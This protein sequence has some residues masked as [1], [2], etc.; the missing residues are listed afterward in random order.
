MNDLDVVQFVQRSVKERKTMVL[1]LL[2]N[3]GIKNMEHYQLCMGELNA[4][5]FIS[6]ELSSL[7]EQQEQFD[8]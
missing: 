7:L 2:E 6:Q 5:N 8:D 3:N 4:L 1:D